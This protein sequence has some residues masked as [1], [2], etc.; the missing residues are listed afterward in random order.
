M[1]EKM[2]EALKEATGEKPDITTELVKK[3]IDD[4]PELKGLDVEKLEE[5]IEVEMEHFDSVDG[6]METIAHI[7]AD[8][9]KENEGYYK[10]LEE[11]EEKLNKSEEDKN[12]ED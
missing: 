6:D 2:E 10:A 11:M 5:G 3:L 1:A 7:A 9:I 4:C 8:H 12:K